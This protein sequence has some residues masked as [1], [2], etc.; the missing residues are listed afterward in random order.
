MFE[1]KEQGIQNP[2]KEQEQE[3]E[4]T[5]QDIKK[6]QK[7]I[8]KAQ[9]D[10]TQLT[11]KGQEMYEKMLK[12]ADMPIRLEDKDIVLGKQE[13]DVRH[14]SR[15]SYRQMEFRQLVLSN[16]YLKQNN[17]TLTDILRL[18]MV[19]A[20]KMGVEDIITAT[21]DIIDKITESE[22]KKQKAKLN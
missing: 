3:P 2:T 21:D 11:P 16:V 4:L 17:Q 12:E 5:E 6:V 10:A 8:K 1:E 19:I 15:A 9:L 22:K 18:L 13:L 7:A 14:L 20:D